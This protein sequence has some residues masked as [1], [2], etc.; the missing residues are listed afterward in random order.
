MGDVSRPKPD[1]VLELVMT[2]LKNKILEFS[3]RCKRTEISKKF[4]RDIYGY[5]ELVSQYTDFGK[6]N[7]KDSI[8]LLKSLLPDQNNYFNIYGLIESSSNFKNNYD[9]FI[10]QLF[11]DILAQILIDSKEIDDI[12]FLINYGKL[13]IQK[14]WPLVLEQYSVIY[15]YLSKFKLNY[16][17]TQFEGLMKISNINTKILYQFIRIESTSNFD[18]N[19]VFKY[20]EQ[21]FEILKNDKDG[22]DPI[23]KTLFHVCEQLKFN[24]PDIKLIIEKI[25]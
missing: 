21:L 1:Q 6:D 11:V 9:L 5:S 17:L 23:V 12:D 15:S 24:S 20:L 19:L 8:S 10:N 22:T 16:L 3:E 2:L 13:L 18:F 7:K 25:N 4:P 14:N